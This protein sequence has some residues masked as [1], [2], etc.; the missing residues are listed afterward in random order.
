M[1]TAPALNQAAAMIENAWGQ[2]IEMLETL[3]VRRPSDDPLLRSTMHIYAALAI[4]DHAVT[5]HQNRLHAL[6]RPGYV[7]AFYELERLTGSAAELRVAHAESHTHLQAIRR[8]IEA[9]EVAAPADRASA[10]RLA[11][12]AVARSGHAQTALGQA[13]DPPPPSTVVGPSAP[14]AGPHR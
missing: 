10:V 2:P 3:A 13:S 12:A 6:T 11:Q 1:P 9:R 7:P 5:A 8:V 4:T 14:A